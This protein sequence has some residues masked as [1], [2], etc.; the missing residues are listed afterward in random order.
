MTVGTGMAA[1]VPVIGS[2]GPLTLAGP[3]NDVR[4]LLLG[5]STVGADALIRF[6][7]LHCVIIPIGM[8]ALMAIHFYR[9]RKDGGVLARY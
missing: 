8:V 6:Y 1:A 2:A 3:T 7:V 5:G 9:V 4:A